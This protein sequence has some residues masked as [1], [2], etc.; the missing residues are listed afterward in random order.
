M[1]PFGVHRADDGFRGGPHHEPL[2]ELL[3]A[4]VGDVGDLRR[5]AFD[6][7]GLLVEQALGDEQWKIRVDVTGRLDSAIQRLLNE[8][9]NRVPVR[10]D[11]HAPFDGRIVGQL[12][13][14]DDIEVPAREVLRLRGNF[15]DER[16]GFIAFVCHRLRPVC[17][18]GATT[19]NTE[20]YSEHGRF[21]M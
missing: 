13:T 7:L 3:A 10:A 21:I 11:N 12:R 5:E 9:P 17:A 18:C 19:V 6:V 15:G 2:F 4:A 1:H 8:L 20:G 16:V 14:P